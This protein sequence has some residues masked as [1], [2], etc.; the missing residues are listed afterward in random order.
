MPGA[1]GPDDV[2]WVRSCP[3]GI[4]LWGSCFIEVVCAPRPTRLWNLEPRWPWLA[5]SRRKSLRDRPPRGSPSP[6]LD[7][8]VP[9]CFAS[10]SLLLRRS[11]LY[12]MPL[13]CWFSLEGGLDPRL[14]IP[15]HTRSLQGCPHSVCTLHLPVWPASPSR[16]LGHG[17]PA[18]QP[19]SPQ[20]LNSPGLR[21]VLRGHLCSAWQALPGSGTSPLTTDA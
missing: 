19:L 3:E 4:A 13:V 2:L 12:F 20:R 7:L 17:C 5:N 14:P 10:F 15:E 1:S 16:C 21:E 8:I 9:C 11:F 18:S 6:G